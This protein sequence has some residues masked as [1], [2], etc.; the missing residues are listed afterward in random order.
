MTKDG[1]DDATFPTQKQQHTM[2]EAAIANTPKG[3]LA[4]LLVWSRCHDM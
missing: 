1:T 2:E 4:M 3:W